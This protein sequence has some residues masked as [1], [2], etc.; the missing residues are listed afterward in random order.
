MNKI[1][2]SV[3]NKATGTWVATSE[4]A[5]S[6][7]KRG[8][9]PKLVM[10]QAVLAGVVM[11]A[12]SVAYAS[13]DAA[14]TYFDASGSG[15]AAFAGP[16][17]EAVAAGDGATATG[18]N[19]I[20]IG[21]NSFASNAN[22][23]A[24]GSNTFSSGT[25]T[26]AGG[27]SARALTD[28]S[29]AVGAYSLTQG[30]AATALGSQATALA[31][32]SLAVGA[33][34][35][36]SDSGSNA[37]AIGVG[38]S[39]TAAS[40]VAL[41][42][43][44][45][46]TAD[47][48]QQG[49]SFGADPT[50]IAGS[51]ATGE[52]SVGSSGNERRVTNVAA[53][54][55]PTD[56]VNVSQ[57]SA[58]DNKVTNL[59]QNTVQYDANSGR[60]SV[61]LAGSTSTDGGV[62]GGTT[63]TNVHRGT[64]SA[65]STDAI[66]GAQLF[67][68]TGDTSATYTANNG[69]G[70]KYVRTN[71]TGLTPDDAH[72]VGLASSA[73]GYDAQANGVRSVAIGSLANAT[74]VASS[75]F[76]FN[77]IATGDGS[78]ALGTLSVANG[79]LSTAIGAA[80]TASGNNSVALGQGSVASED[81]TVSVGSAGSERR[82]TNVA[83]GV[84]PTDAV[85][86]S[87]LTAV[88]NSAAAGVKYFKATG[89][90]DG[91]DAASAS[92]PYSVAMGSSALASG[93]NSLAAGASSSATGTNSIAVGS[94]AQATAQNATAIGN[95]AV[96]SA[97]GSV[98]LGQGSVADRAN[99]VSVGSAGNERQ[100]T[101]VAAG[102]EGTD[103]VNVNQLNAVASQAAASAAKIDGAVTYDT[104]PDGSVNKNSVTLGG[105]SGTVIHDVAD[106]VLAT[107]A[108]NLSQLDAAIGSAIGNLQP[109]AGSTFFSANGD[110]TTEAAQASGTHTTAAG[111]NAQAS[112]TNA[113]AIGANSTASGNNATALGAG[114]NAS[115]DNAVALGQGSVADRANTVSVGAAGSE[116]QITNVAAG[117][118]GTD[119]VNVN[120]LNSSMSNAVGEANGYTDDQIRSARRDSYGGTASALAAA[121]LPQAVLPG[122][123][124][125]AVAGGTYAGQSAIALGVSQLSE[126][127]KWVYK[128]QG[129]SDSRGQFGASVGAGMH[130]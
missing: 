94:Y 79:T 124:M 128:V 113:V 130:W 29:T 111:A 3:W 51:T 76:G 14:A 82:I 87:Q 40:S 4:T 56:A 129:T 85:N 90:E 119:A 123:G 16:N 26:F 101:N 59:A 106:G 121:G 9:S 95:L 102:V 25:N 13:A 37:V 83:A 23:T 5:R 55:A 117:V 68:I 50:T 67:G 84:D 58:V 63:L 1:Y 34:A 28:N 33:G 65:T 81:N 70:V 19:S 18:Q 38:A 36:V 80:A 89:A 49:Q 15:V 8:V 71:D 72:A 116:R 88:A 127:G 73:V 86:V 96:A 52:V 61:T 93:A 107:D 97:E 62:T 110:T 53:G 41:G 126:T 43:N 30:F 7:T 74:G 57:L 114:A 2:K 45:T 48:T 100:I 66:N 118:Q 32:N 64:V 39:A 24:I 98:A 44:S 91:S 108:V 20:A 60:S 11:M 17:V 103:A 12:G 22:S 105:D 21:S 54:A 6:K 77:A 92:G 35:K 75:S 104:N 109:T 46:T 42:A 112:G 10:A 122:H 115:T 78:T 47:L 120:Q 125:V 69:T 27:S 99:T 31:I